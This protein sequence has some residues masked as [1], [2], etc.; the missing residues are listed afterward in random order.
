MIIVTMSCGNILMFYL[1]S[2]HLDLLS[3]TYMESQVALVVK[4]NLPAETGDA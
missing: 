2:V 4:K 3:N 1:A